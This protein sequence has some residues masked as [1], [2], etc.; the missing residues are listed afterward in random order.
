MK[1]APS[2]SRSDPFGQTDIT[3]LTVIF[4]KCLPNMR[5]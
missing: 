3:K 4:R 5:Y 1:I 2:G